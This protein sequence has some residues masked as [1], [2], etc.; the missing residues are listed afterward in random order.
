V[1]LVWDQNA[2]EDYT[3]T[4]AEPRALLSGATPVVEGY[5]AMHCAAAVAIDDPE[6]VSAK[7][8]GRLLDAWRG[9]AVVNT[10][11]RQPLATQPGCPISNIMSF[12]L[13]GSPLPRLF[14]QSHERSLIS[15][16]SHSFVA[17]CVQTHRTAHR[18]GADPSHP[19]LSA[20][21]QRT[22]NK[23]ETGHLR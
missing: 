8:A 21:T 16:K 9:L 22:D 4:G 12:G 13:E 23:I 1:R 20:H 11:S 6:L 3:T 7:G 19:N 14:A 10:L 18:M 15:R 17:L 2:W 5:D